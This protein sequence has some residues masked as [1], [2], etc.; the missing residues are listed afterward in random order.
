MRS[1]LCALWARTE[2]RERRSGRETLSVLVV[3]DFGLQSMEECGMEELLKGIQSGDREAAVSSFL[4]MSREQQIDLLDKLR[5]VR[6]EAVGAFLGALLPRVDEKPVQKTIKKLLFLL[7]TQGISVEAP[8]IVGEPVLR[9]VEVEREQ[10]AFLSNYDPEGT[11]A[12]LLAFEMKKRQ[13]VFAHA[14]AHF[15][16]GLQDLV[17]V[18]IP[19]DELDSILKEYL[20]RTLRPA[21]LSPIS[22]RYAAYLIDEASTLSGKFSDELKDLR[23]LITGLKGEIQRPEDITAL[24]VPEGTSSR[25][26]DAI[27]A[28]P[29]FESFTLTWDTMEQDKKDLESVL[30]PG[31]VL[32]PYVVEER[33]QAFLKDL[34]ASE[35]FKPTARLMKRLLQD[36]A[37][38]F[39]AVGEFESFRGIM[40]RLSDEQF[41]QGALFF[42]VRK[43]FEKK[44][45]EKPGVLVDPYK[46]PPP[47]QPPLLGR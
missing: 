21:V 46:Q 16:K 43:A 31:I 10:S 38:L 1:S 11:R 28:N 29:M 4:A 45:E 36:Y 27:L 2:T 37:Y 40:D 3:V 47:G 5:A 30:N 13:F 18:P 8:K 44:E 33:R 32:P 24:K 35:K 15:S 14:I 34:T 41:L 23:P 39:H 9:R 6:S 22:P 12:I 19:K 17:I 26:I 7:K 20:S 42:F 25:G